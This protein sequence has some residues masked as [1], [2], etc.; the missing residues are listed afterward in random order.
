MLGM[1]KAIVW[2]RLSHNWENNEFENKYP[3]W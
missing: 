1:E 2:K 3:L